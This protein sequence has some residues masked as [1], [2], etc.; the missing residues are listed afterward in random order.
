MEY[1]CIDLKCFYASVECV[2]RGLDPYTTPLVVADESRGKGTICLA[3]STKMK[4]L[5]VKN[6]CRLFQIPTHIKYMIAKPRM[7]KYID[8]AAKIYGIYLKYIAKEDIHVYSI[9]EAFLDVTHYRNLYQKSGSE[10]G[11]M[12]M[13]DIYDT[14]G[15]TA[16][17][18]VG[19]N[20]YLAKIALDIY[21][22]KI[23][24]NIAYL[25]EKLYKEKLGNHLPLTDFW[26]IGKGIS[27]R[28][29]KLGL[30]TMID[31]ANAN[32]DDLYKEF[33][34][35]AS[36]LIEHAHG[37]ESTKISDIKAYKPKAKSVSNGQILE[38]NYTYNEALLAVKEMVELLCLELIGQKQVTNH[39]SL[40]VGY[41]DSL[42]VKA[43]GGSRKLDV[44][45]NS[46]EIL[47][48]EIVNLYKERTHKN[49]DIRR[50]NVAFGN[51]QDESCESYSLF[52]DVE[53][54]EKEKKLLTTVH[55][56]KEKYGNSSV[57][58]LMNLEESATTIKRNKLIGGHNAE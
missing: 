18:G 26:Q 38:R 10:I 31:V 39:I 17:C 54:I 57:M 53:R 28:L 12:I 58:R 33:G 1:L 36:F 55:Q 42:N 44:T 37:R 49:T 8:Y 47:Y 16:T 45:T 50:L 6:R 14:T 40:G 25:D 2:E 19:T 21:A 7:K 56:I 4:T 11:K 27:K 29:N 23:N 9:D 46:Y 15:L 52:D 35:N 32:E 22:K 30:N 20:L 48:K 51:L 3:I 5:G 13:D 41:D 24:S 43:T 34:V